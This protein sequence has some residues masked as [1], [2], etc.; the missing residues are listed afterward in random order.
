M[1]IAT[2]AS[3]I[4]TERKIAQPLSFKISLEEFIQ[5]PPE[6]AEW[7]NS[8]I[9]V[10]QNMGFLHSRLQVELASLLL[11]FAKANN[12]GGIVCTELLCRT[13]KQARKPDVAYMSAKQVE[14][15]GKT[16][17]TTL[18]ECFPLVIE[19]ASPTDTAEDIFSKTEE[20]LEAG[21]EEIWLVFPRN[22]LIIIATLEVVEEK[23]DVQWNLFANNQQATS[24]KVLLGFSVNINELLP[25]YVSK[26]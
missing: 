17:F 4:Q 16:D 21:A 24:P 12:L 13:L 11:A 10:K 7:V 25:N 1:T 6:N 14:D 26:S 5:N 3:P 8:Q 23:L 9:I 20:Y 2:I 19:I 22:K 15:Y 18:P